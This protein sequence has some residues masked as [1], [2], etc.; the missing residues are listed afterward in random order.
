ME[1]NSARNPAVFPHLESANRQGIAASGG[2]VAVAWEDNRSG[3]SRCYVAIKPAAAVAFQP[4]RAISGDECYEPVIASLGQGRFLAA[5]E[6]AGRVYARVWPDGQSVRLSGAAAAQLTLATGNGNIHAAWA[7][8]AGPYQR[9]V[10]ASLALDGVRV[11]VERVQPVEAA[12]PAGE[13]AWPALAENGMGG[14]TVIWEDRREKHTVPLASRGDARLNFAPPVHITDQTSGR[15]GGL[16]AGFGAMRPTLVSWGENGTVAVWLDKRDFLSGYDVYAAFDAGTGRFGVNQR[17]QDGFGDNLAQWHAQVVA[18]KN[19]LVVVWDDARDG[20]PD[21]WLANWD[22]SGFSENVAV[23]AAS[24]P[25]EQSDPVAT[26]DDT[27]TLH[28][29]WLDRHADGTRVRYARAVW[30]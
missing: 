8:Q 9:I 23:P 17:V 7:E 20:T 3:V 4:E 24:G 25:G 1:V 11:K 26:L 14:V 10:V 2:A 28:L 27:G 21:V 29:S 19:R 22:G 6:E 30:K 18:G 12:M 15:T 16:G 13:Q 5:W